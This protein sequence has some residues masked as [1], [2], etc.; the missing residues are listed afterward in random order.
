MKR[1]KTA[2]KNYPPLILLHDMSPEGV[3]NKKDE[4]DVVNANEGTIFFTGTGGQCKQWIHDNVHAKTM[5]KEAI[6]LLQY[7]VDRVEAG[8]AH[9]KTTYGKYKEF[10]QRIKND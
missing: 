2:R 1:T 10:L 6:D 5:L 8:T 3:K 4:W 7:F 9:S